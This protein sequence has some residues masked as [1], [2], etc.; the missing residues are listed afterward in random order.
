MI[1]AFDLGHLGKAASRFDND[2]LLSLN[3]QHMMKAPAALLAAGLRDQ[4]A[5]LGINTSDQPLL[6]GVANAQRERARTLKEMATNSQ[7]FFRDFAEFDAKAAAKN[8]NAESA[9]LLHA[10]RAALVELQDWSASAVHDLIT[11]LA[12]GHSVGMGKLAQ[13]LRVAV[14]G[15]GVS[16]PIDQTVALLGRDKVLARLDRALMVAGR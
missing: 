8:L 11:A 16:P 7:F 3:A 1:A 13:P 6:E 2:K 10:L 4:L 5:R 14:S 15:G 9:P 12:A